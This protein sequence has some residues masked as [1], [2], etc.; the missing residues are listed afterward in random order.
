MPGGR[1]RKTLD[2]LPNNWKEKLLELGSRGA[3][4]V[5]MRVQLGGICHRTW[6][7]LIDEYP[8]FCET[9]KEARA[10]CQ[11]WWEDIAQNNM[12]TE[13]GES[14][15]ATTWIFN[16]KNRFNWRDKSEQSHDHTS[17]GE[18]LSIAPGYFA[19]EDQPKV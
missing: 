7:Q 10:R 18:K 14:F 9:V 12:L 1:P 15:N 5:K 4:D 19:G 13:K 17:K 11:E 16:M 8:E 2:D 3:S 6:E